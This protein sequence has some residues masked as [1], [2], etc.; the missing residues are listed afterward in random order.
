MMH[1]TIREAVLDDL[2]I[3]SKMIAD[4]FS[5]E[6][7]FEINTDKQIAALTMIIKRNTDGVILIAEADSLAAGMINLQRIVSTA[8]GGFSVLL[9]DLY[10]KHDLRNKGIG[11]MLLQRA[12]LWGKK[13]QAMRIQLGADIRNKS[14]IDFYSSNGFVKSNMALHYK[15][16]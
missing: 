3:L 2:N 16:I 9:E 1:I 4:L 10:V 12:A 8:A 5:I 15:M 13:H 11:G 7:D 14:A 6:D